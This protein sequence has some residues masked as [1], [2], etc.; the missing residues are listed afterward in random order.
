MASS[1]PTGTEAARCREESALRTS[2]ASRAAASALQ[3][4]VPVPWAGA[5]PGGMDRAS[6]AAPAHWQ[7]PVAGVDRR[8]AAG[9][10]RWQARCPAE[11]LPVGGPCCGW[12]GSSG[13]PPPARDG[14]GAALAT[15]AARA[16]QQGPSETP[17]LA[18]QPGLCRGTSL[19]S[20]KTIPTHLGHSL[21]KA[22][23]KNEQ[24]DRRT[25]R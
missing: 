4:K 5:S 11:V 2:A 14:S 17:D 3:V 21:K 7:V 23:L 9:G 18:G 24:P 13:R 12:R 25:A 1:L 22:P 8:G 10:G 15:A 19:G 20:T 6:C 16:R